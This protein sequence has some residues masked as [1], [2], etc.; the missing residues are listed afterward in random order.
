LEVS[1]NGASFPVDAFVAE[2]T[3]GSLNA[4]IDA[5]VG[6]T[7]LQD[8][9]DNYSPNPELQLPGAGLTPLAQ[10]DAAGAITDTTGLGAVAIC[11]GAL[12]NSGAGGGAADS[13]DV[14]KLMVCD[15]TDPVMVSVGPNAKRGGIVGDNLGA[16]TWPAEALEVVCE[17]GCVTCPGDLSGDGMISPA[18]YTLMITLLTA[19][20][21]T[22]T[23]MPGDADYN[24]CA[25]L[26]GDGM[27]SPADYTLMITQLTAAAP[28]YTIPCN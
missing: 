27:I 12:D 22:Y 28:T 11:V 5:Y 13:A 2:S 9:I 15:G 20:A 14:A 18:D 8:M 1:L 6:N 3:K 23:I 4:Y 26:S 24:P 21:P 25:D 17:Q 10:L 7:V 19:A 16:I